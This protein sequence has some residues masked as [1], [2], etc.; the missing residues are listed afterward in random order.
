LT[1]QQRRNRLLGRAAR[2]ALIAL[3]ALLAVGCAPVA[4][5]TAT[6]AAAAAP[7]LKGELTVFA[8]ASLT[9][10]FT[11]VGAAL[12]AANPGSTVTLNFAGSSALRTQLGEGAQ[13][14]VLASADQ[15]NMQKAQDAGVIAGEPQV[16]ARNSLVIITPAQSEAGIAAP[17]DLANAGIRLVIGQ[18][19]LPA[20]NY[21]RQVLA[22]MDADPAYGAGFLDKVLANV[23]SEENN[24][25]GI[26]AKVQLGE[27]DAGIVY[28]TDV[29]AA[30]SAQVKVIEIP[31]ELNVIASYPIAI[32]AGAGNAAGAQAFIDYLLSPAGQ[33]ALEKQ[34]FMRV[35]AQ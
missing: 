13:A 8:A 35:D 33:D 25:K 19:D 18:A 28:A 9:A 30:V 1:S 6:P 5:P 16:F 29:T 22:R 2:C 32:V 3:V 12:E 23:V 17:K 11:D 27:A 14:D 34:G 31:E 26:V 7:A 15:A 4:Q 20:G 10:A 21:A 24:V